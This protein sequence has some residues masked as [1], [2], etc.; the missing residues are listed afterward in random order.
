MS[1]NVYVKVAGSQKQVTAIKTKVSGTW[2]N[3][4]AAYV[5]VSG[6]WK[7][8]FSGQNRNKYKINGVNYK[9]LIQLTKQVGR[10]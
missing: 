4:T 5:K 1:T 10:C 9:W 6:T 3:I 2:K 7:Q 8:I